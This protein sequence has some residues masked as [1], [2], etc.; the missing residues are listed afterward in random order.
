IV[1]TSPTL[2]AI[3]SEEPVNNSSS[4]VHPFLRTSVKTAPI[5]L[6]TA[7]DVV[8]H[9]KYRLVSALFSGVEINEGMNSSIYGHFVDVSRSDNL[10]KHHSQKRASQHHAKIEYTFLETY[11]NNRGSLLMNSKYIIS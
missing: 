3:S 11:S 8:T 2:S 7:K 1:S 6:I 5:T 10:P 9:E 4:T